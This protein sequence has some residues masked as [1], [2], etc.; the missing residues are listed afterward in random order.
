[1]GDRNQV[2]VVSSGDGGGGEGGL[3]KRHK[4]TLGCRLGLELLSAGYTWVYVFV[5]T[6][7]YT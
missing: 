2:S 6:D 1:M 3:Q 4:R 5:K 7:V